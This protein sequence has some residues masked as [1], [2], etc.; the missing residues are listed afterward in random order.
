MDE[1]ERLMA[2]YRDKV[3]RLC[4]AMLGDRAL[5]EETAQ[6]V[7]IRVWKGLGSYRGQ[8]SVSTWIYAIARNT[9]LTA[10][11]MKAAHATVSLESPGVAAEAEARH[12][13]APARSGGPDVLAAVAQLPEKHRQ[14]L[15][16]YHM[17]E[18]SYEEVAAMLD[19]PMGTVKTY[20]HRARRELARTLAGGK[21]ME[22]C[23]P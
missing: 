17:E 16:L 2:A 14:A 1:F 21:M 22:G 15:L 23:R 18:R 8:S 6:E 12:A 10:L 20:L 13:P 5:A 7:F 11:R 19:L 9:C 3:F 4:W